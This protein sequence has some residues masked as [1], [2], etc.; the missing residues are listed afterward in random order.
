MAA[1]TWLDTGKMWWSLDM[2]NTD[3]LYDNKLGFTHLM[4]RRKTGEKQRDGW[5]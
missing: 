2:E 5:F 1:T 3:I 4:H